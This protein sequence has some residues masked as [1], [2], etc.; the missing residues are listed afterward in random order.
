MNTPKIAVVAITFN[1]E[2]FLPS[3]LDSIIEQRNNNIA[4]IIV[5]DCSTDN[6]LS[7]AQAYAK[8]DQRITIITPPK[9]GGSFHARLIGMQ[10]A[11]TQDN[12]NDYLLLVDGDDLLLP[13]CLDTL[14]RTAQTTNAD[15]V[16]FGMVKEINGKRIE[17][18]WLVPRTTPLYGDDVFERF[19]S[20][21]ISHNMVTKFYSMEVVRKMLSEPL[22]NSLGS[23]RLTNAEDYLL[24]L[25]LFRH[26]QSYFPIKDRL[27]VYRMRENSATGGDNPF[28]IS[29]IIQ[30]YRPT[31][32]FGKA[33][34][35]STN[36]SMDKL[37]HLETEIPRR[38]TISV[39]TDFL[40]LG[41]I[42]ATNSNPQPPIPYTTLE[43]TTQRYIHSALSGN[44]PRIACDQ[45]TP[46]SDKLLLQVHLGDDALTP[47]TQPI[48]C[49][50]WMLATRMAQHR[51]KLWSQSYHA[52]ATETKSSFLYAAIR[53]SIKR[54]AGRTTG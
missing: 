13:G 4:L 15:I 32:L 34:C 16:H 29:H 22:L 33:Y 9:N 48:K 20:R 18:S 53:N 52:L 50:Y 30:K 46:P 28:R 5:D 24:C 23:Y 25:M 12:P 36:L 37:K 49:Y 6:T 10:A 26:A 2:P 19:A 45:H 31:Y 3:C 38:I 27:Y 44:R 11:A 43:D 1:L 21:Y 17:Q 54:L 8:K 40:P 7:I 14:V 41:P 35:E 47:P 39:L 42:D 51:S